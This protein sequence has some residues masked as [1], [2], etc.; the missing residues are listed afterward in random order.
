MTVVDVLLAVYRWFAAIDP[1]IWQAIVAGVFVAAGWIYN[2]WRDRRDARA[3][4]VEKRRD[5]H[6]AIY[7][8]IATN[9]SNLA[10]EDQIDALAQRVMAEMDRDPNY[11]PFVPRPARDRIFREFEGNI[12]IL[13]RVTIDRIVRYY[14]LLD[15]I[16]ALVED[17]RGET[18][19][20]LDVERRKAIFFDYSEMQKTARFF[21]VLANSLID[22]F[23]NQGVAAARELEKRLLAEDAARREALVV[24]RPN[25]DPSDP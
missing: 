7:A 19:K 9:L 5:V 21:G 16:D 1:R 23:E 14:F 12:Q 25:V 24:S 11:M 13:P 10:E 22:A 17:M 18:F 8:E 4:R 20:S 15:S 3:L 2:G 6:R